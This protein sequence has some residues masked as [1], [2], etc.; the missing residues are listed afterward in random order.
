MQLHRTMTAALA[1]GVFAVTPF[2][3]GAQTSPAAPPQGAPSQGTPSQGSPSQGTPSQGTPTQGTPSQAA[4]PDTTGAQGSTKVD[5]S[6]LASALT[7]LD[8]SI[9]SVKSLNNVPLSSIQLVNA[10]EIVPAG[11]SSKALTDVV[12]KKDT[13]IQSLRQALHNVSVSDTANGNQT[14]TFSSALANLSSKTNAQSAVTID[15]VIAVNSGTNG[16]LTVFYK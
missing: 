4:P 3:A 8:A 12:A 11:K 13:Q 1:F 5:I 14:L 10:S 15:R 2:V 6:V 9:S 16:S 7:N